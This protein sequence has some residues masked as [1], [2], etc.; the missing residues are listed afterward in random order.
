[1]QKSE[2][3]HRRAFFKPHA[4]QG[5]VFD[6]NFSFLLN[7]TQIQLSLYMTLV[8]GGRKIEEAKPSDKSYVQRNSLKF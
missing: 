8:V 2:R 7:V 4:L 3:S 5:H 6:L 1:M